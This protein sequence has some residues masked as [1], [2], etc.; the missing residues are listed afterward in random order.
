MVVS[1]TATLPRQTKRRISV[2]KFVGGLLPPT[3][4]HLIV[5][6]HRRGGVVELEVVRINLPVAIGKL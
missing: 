1:R 4:E 3:I 5:S 6:L 2:D